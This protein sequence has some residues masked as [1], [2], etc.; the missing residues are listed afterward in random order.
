MN[1]PSLEEALRGALSDAPERNLHYVTHFR[2]PTEGGYQGYLTS[3][4]GRTDIRL[5]HEI[6]EIDPNARTLQFS[7]G[8]STGYEHL[9]SSIP[10]PDL[11]PRIKGAPDDVLAAAQRLAFSSVVLVNLGIDRAGIG[12]QTHIRYVYDSDI[13]FSRISFPHRL[14]PRVVPD[15]ASAIQVEWYFS[16]KYK[17]LETSPESLIEPTVA[18][19]RSMGLLTQQ[20]QVLVSEASFSRYANVIYDHERRPAVA[21]IQE[22][23]NRVGIHSCG[24]YGE[25]NHLWTDESF[26]SGEAAAEAAVGG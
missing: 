4:V 15:N 13:P 9:I 6:V 10:L 5:E 24:R 21:M 12:G 18:H 22:F 2:Y 25:W 17:P 8:A 1:R 3:W 20:D 7:T 16:E 14:S 11:V 23:L 26:L 19:L